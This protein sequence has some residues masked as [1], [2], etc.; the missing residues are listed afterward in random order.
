MEIIL[1]GVTKTFNGTREKY[2]ALERVDLEIADGEFVCLLGP[3]GCGKTTILNLIAGLENPS[4]GQVRVDG[5]PVVG[6]GPD[7]TVMFQEAALFPWMTVIDNVRFALRLAGWPRDDIEA[8]ARDFLSRVHLSR[9][10]ENAVHELS[11]GMRQRVALARA[12]AVDPK[13]LLM[14][15]PFAALDA[16]TRDVLHGELQRLFMDSPKSVVFVTHNVREAVVL[17]DRVVVLET[18]PGRI[19]EEFRIDWPRPRDPNERDMAVLSARIL[20]ALK[21]EIDKVM[22]EES[23]EAWRAPASRLPPAPDRNVGSGI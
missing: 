2:T 14:D 21:D 9:F 4:T 19:K 17:G 8:R 18:Q 6:P 13:V 7:R 15:E 16:Q 5:R 20:G 3:S 23:D 12:L 10:A 1:D 22:R 11:G